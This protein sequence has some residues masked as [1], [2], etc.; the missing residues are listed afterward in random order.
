MITITLHELM[1][2]IPELVNLFLSGFIFMTIYS[3]FINK[4]LDISTVAIWS[5]FISTL[6]KTF[7]SAVHSVILT[8]YDINDYLK[9]L[10]YVIT[11]TFLPFIIIFI[12]NSKLISFILFKAD[13]KSINSDIFDDIIDY[14]KN[15]LLQ[16]YL[17]NS[18]VMYIGTFKLRE[19]K[20]L[21][22]YIV[23]INYASLDKNTKEVTFNPAD[24]GLQSAVAINLGDIERI[25]LSYEHDSDVWKWLSGKNGEEIKNNEEDK[26]DTNSNKT[27]KQ[28]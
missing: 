18:N 27:N 2:I 23:L 16:I 14:H 20:G 11:G 13:N 19:E 22:S 28:T 5:L 6:I 4:E 1:N 21:D 25:E 26:N 24:N 8:S 12:K 17:K 15:T 10:I 9:V 3:W 7:Y